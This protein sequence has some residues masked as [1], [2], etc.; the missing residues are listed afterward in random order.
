MRLFVDAQRAVEAAEQQ[1]QQLFGYQQEYSQKLTATDSASMSPHLLRDY[2]SF[3]AKLRLSI[4][5]IHIDIE[6]KKQFCE[7]QKQAWLKCRSRSHALNSVVEK[8]KLEEFK[9]QEKYE[10][11]EQDEHAQ[12]IVTKPD[13]S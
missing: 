5:Q 11:K 10:Q 8:Y 7:I 12:R 4:E 6:N 13:N 9:Q 1:L 3:I 2:Q